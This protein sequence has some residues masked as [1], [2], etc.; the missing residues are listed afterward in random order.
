M[1]LPTVGHLELAV[2]L[3]VARLGPEAY[4]ASIRREL[5]GRTGRD[6]ALG[7]IHTTLQR[8]EDKGLVVS[9]MSEPIAVRGGRARR[10]FRV[11]NLGS[12]VIR[13]ARTVESA[14]WQGIPNWSTT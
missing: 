14:L 5:T 4:G 2:L 11:T 13:H 8:I 9:M 7:A 3:T 10:C 12:R 1:P 6:H